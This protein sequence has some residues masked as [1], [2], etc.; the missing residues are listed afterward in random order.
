MKRVLIQAALSAA[1]L[2]ASSYSQAAAAPCPK[3]PP[4]P[5]I[6]VFPS[7]YTFLEGTSIDPTD[8][9]PVATGATSFTIS[10][11]ITSQTGLTFDTTTGVISGT[12]TA[13]KTTTVYTV[14]AFNCAGKRAFTPITVA[15]NDIAPAISLP[16]G[17]YTFLVGAKIEDIVPTLDAT[18][19]SVSIY[20]DITST[21]LAFNAKTGKIS[22]TPTSPLDLSYVLT[23]TNGTGQTAMANLTVNL[24]NVIPAVAPP[25]STGPGCEYKLTIADFQSTNVSTTGGMVVTHQA[26]YAGGSQ[27]P[28]GAD[29]FYHVPL[30]DANGQVIVDSPAAIASVPWGVW[31]VERSAA[32]FTAGNSGHQNDGGATGYVSYTTAA[33]VSCPITGIKNVAGA[34]GFDDE[35]EAIAGV[36]GHAGQDQYTLMG[37]TIFAESTT[38]TAA[39]LYTVT[40]AA[41]PPPPPTITPCEAYVQGCTTCDASHECLVCDSGYTL[42]AGTCAVPVTVP[43]Q[44][45]ITSVTVPDGVFS[46]ASVAFTAASNGGLP[47]TGYTVTSSPGGIVGFGLSSPI[48]VSGLTNGEEYTFTVVAANADGNSPVSAA[49]TPPFEPLG[50][51]NAPTITSVISGDGQTTVAFSD[52]SNGGV[53]ITNFMLVATPAGVNGSSVTGSSS[54]LTLTGLTDGQTYTF[55]VLAYNE[56][57]W[58]APS[59]PVTATPDGL[60]GQASISVIVGAESVIVSIT[61]PAVTG[62]AGELSYTITSMPTSQTIV[63]S[64]ATDPITVSGLV[65]GTEYLFSVVASNSVGASPAGTSQPVTPSRFPGSPSISGVDV[66]SGQLVVHIADPAVTGGAITLYTVIANPGDYSASS[67]TQ[68]VTITGLENGV[69]YTV[70]A[71]VSNSD[72]AGPAVT[73]TQSYALVGVPC[74]PNIVGITATGT[75][76]LIDV[77]PTTCDGGDPITSWTVTEMPD[78]LVQTFYSTPISWA[79]LSSFQTYTFTLVAQS[80]VGIS[81]TSQ[82]FEV[83]AGEAA[84]IIVQYSSENPQYIDAQSGYIVQSDYSEVDPYTSVLVVPRPAETPALALFDGDTDLLLTQDPISGLYT[85]NYGYTVDITTGNEYDF[86]GNNIGLFN[87]Y[88]LYLITTDGFIVNV[89]DLQL[90]LSPSTLAGVQEQPYTVA[91]TPPEYQINN[92]PPMM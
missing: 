26:V 30:T 9:V 19:S 2:T 90:E 15:V 85:S 73:S 55:T 4:L 68:P 77:D 58:G 80:E 44:P 53:A 70:S 7:A 27:V 62:G 72:G 83:S 21:G 49:S 46:T 18:V 75:V 12:P 56:E 54:P 89:Q 32:S 40:F 88:N 17:P 16:P 11:D 63:T 22:G 34:D 78:N 71:Y 43:S 45:I 5:T 67:A 14:A 79:G 25:A 33:T 64:D 23:A 41:P 92:G 51:P 57:G 65:D 74:S 39:D 76:A 38:T 3:T 84:V 50:P 69:E 29:G 13:G 87:G 1:S 81:P 24:N 28:L 20:P 61:P 31:E 86:Q 59:A 6:T 10:P 36:I 47:I 60:P 42:S 37:N 52:G 66:S 35:S 48:A 82:P 91:P 8:I